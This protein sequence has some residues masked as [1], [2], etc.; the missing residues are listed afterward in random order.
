MNDNKENSNRNTSSTETQ[1]DINKSDISTDDKIL[2]LNTEAINKYLGNVDENL[3]VKFNMYENIFENI[4]EYTT[5]GLLSTEYK[6][7]VFTSKKQKKSMLNVLQY[8]ENKLQKSHVGFVIMALIDWSHQSLYYIFN[9]PN[10]EYK[11]LETNG[12]KIANIYFHS[13][14]YSWTH[15]FKS[16]IKHKNK[17]PNIALFEVIL[18][19]KPCKPY[20]DIEWII[21]DNSPENIENINKSFVNKVKTDII[22]IFELSYGI[23]L[24]RSDIK[25]TTAHRNKKMSFHIIISPKNQYVAFSTNVKKCANSAYDLANKLL[26]INNDFYM[27]KI[28]MGVYTTDRNMRVV[29]S[30]KTDVINKSLVGQLI[31][32]ANKKYL[33]LEDMDVSEIV[34]YII[35]DFSKNKDKEISFIETKEHNDNL[36]QASK[37]ALTY[38]QLMDKNNKKFKNTVLKGSYIH[39]SDLAMKVLQIIQKYHESA[40]IDSHVDGKLSFVCNYSDRNEPCFDKDE[41]GNNKYHKSNRFYANV[42]LNSGDVVVHCLSQKCGKHIKIGNIDESN[43]FLNNA[44][45]INMQY[46]NYERNFNPNDTRTDFEQTIDNFL[47]NGGVL[48]IK[49]AMGT[50]KTQFIKKLLTANINGLEGKYKKTLLSSHVTFITHRI[51]LTTS[52][53]ETFKELNIIS[54]LDN[55]NKDFMENKMFFITSLDSLPKRC[56]ENGKFVGDN[57]VL[58]IDEGESVLK[59]HSSDTMSDSKKQDVSDMSTHYIKNCPF[60]VVTCGDMGD[61]TCDLIIG[62]TGKSPLVIHNTYEKPIEP[63]PEKTVDFYETTEFNVKEHIKKIKEYNELIDRENKKMDKI[64][65]KLGKITKDIDEYT[66]EKKH[67]KESEDESSD[68]ENKKKKKN[69]ENADKITNKEPTLNPDLKPKRFTFRRKNNVSK[70]FVYVYTNVDKLINNI[71]RDARNGMKLVLMFSSQKTLRSVYRT[72]CVLLPEFNENNWICLYD[73]KSSDSDKRSMGDVNSIWTKY[74]IVMY[75]STIESGVDYNQVGV[76]DRK[77]AFLSAG[78]AG[79]RP[80]FQMYGRV[81]DCWD[82]DF[83]VYMPRHLR[84]APIPHIPPVLYFKHLIAKLGSKI[85]K[86]TKITDPKTGNTYFHHDPNLIELEAKNNREDYENNY[87][88]GHTFFKKAH[89]CGFVIVDVDTDDNEIKF[90]RNDNDFY[91]KM[92]Q[93]YNYGNMDDNDVFIYNTHETPQYYF[94]ND[95]YIFTKEQCRITL[96]DL[97][98]HIIMKAQKEK[99]N[100]AKSQVKDI[101]DKKKIKDNSKDKQLSTNL[102]SIKII[103]NEDDDGEAKISGNIFNMI[104]TKHQNSKDSK[105][106]N[107]IVIDEDNDGEAKIKGNILKKIM[108]TNYIDDEEYAQE[109]DIATSSYTVNDNIDT[110]NNLQDDDEF[111]MITVTS[112]NEILTDKTNIFHDICQH[113]INQVYEAKKLMVSNDSDVETTNINKSIDFE[114]IIENSIKK[115]LN[116]NKVSNTVLN[117]FELQ[118]KQYIPANKKDKKDKKNKKEPNMVDINNDC[119]IQYIISAKLITLNEAD[120]LKNKEKE[121]NMSEKEKYEYL[122]YKFMKLIAAKPSDMTSKFVEK[123]YPHM[124]AIRRLLLLIKPDLYKKAIIKDD[125][126]TKQSEVVWKILKIFGIVDKTIDALIEAKEFENDFVND[127]NDIKRLKKSGFLIRDNYIEIMNVFGRIVRTDT[128]K[129]EKIVMSKLFTEIGNVILRKYMLKIVSTRKGRDKNRRQVYNIDELEPGIFD[130]VLK[131]INIKENKNI[132]NMSENINIRLIPT[133]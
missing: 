115:I 6:S 113:F 58:I 67:I 17:V 73:S 60:V 31:P 40:Y 94:T 71:V 108:E 129:K 22:S 99:D 127:E 28:D 109:K 19:S 46:L 51:S 64:I 120:I 16:F 45:E 74:R 48:L 77:Y 49:S 75:T 5:S 69:K 79:V 63:S 20:L 104:E 26:T 13:C 29:F 86:K 83:Y 81:R 43:S 10:V 110:F 57:G 119:L 32:Y 80:L 124:D 106:K 36:K 97:H 54:Y 131:I 3:I 96:L 35:T 65:K 98:N 118:M 1:T 76:F 117:S 116:D 68:E 53:T 87:A 91:T 90:L 85:A 55:D 52:L 61:R 38:N 133:E 44:L 21:E 111:K 125:K 12:L 9:R 30:H 84:Y 105:G 25:I 4:C 126:Y 24:V 47:V 114:S 72:L 56:D 102:K 8:C 42:H 70:K 66:S 15:I 41:D 123:W 27:N 11:I 95:K 39:L 130:T 128:N 37:E 14:H 121:N 101:K 62:L 59:H 112:F 23:T 88:Y 100:V 50:G 107:K 78:G 7:Y 122:K 92:I 132:N 2:Y 18:S 82:P 89:S 103:I 34:D 33:K 93:K